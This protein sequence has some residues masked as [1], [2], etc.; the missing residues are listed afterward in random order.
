MFLTAFSC[1][2]RAFLPGTYLFHSKILLFFHIGGNLVQFRISSFVFVCCFENIIFLDS[3]ECF[4]SWGTFL[5]FVYNNVLMTMCR[6]LK[7]TLPHGNSAKSFFIWF[8]YSQFPFWRRTITAGDFHCLR[9]WMYR[10]QGTV[11]S[12][13]KITVCY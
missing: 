8:L 10:D 6:K 3:L 7:D 13:S 9:H 12:S 1:Q 2:V 5:D 4:S 11:I